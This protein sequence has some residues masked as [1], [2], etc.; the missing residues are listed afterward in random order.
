MTKREVVKFLLFISFFSR[1]INF[2]F[3]YFYKMLEILCFF[4]TFA[5]ILSYLFIS[6]CVFRDYFF[7]FFGSVIKK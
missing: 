5:L 6:F 3:D 2:C 4:H 1:K 7:F